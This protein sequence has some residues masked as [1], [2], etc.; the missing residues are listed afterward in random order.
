MCPCASDWSE[1]GASERSTQDPPRLLRRRRGRRHRP[2]ADAARAVADSSRSGS[3]PSP[4]DCSPGRRRLRHRDRDAGPRAHPAPR[5]RGRRADLLR[6]AGRR[7][8][9][10][11][12]AS[13]PSS[14]TQTRRP[15]HVG[16]QRRFDR[17]YRRAQQAV[18]RRARLRAQHPGADPRPVAA[19]R[20]LHPDERRPLPRLL[21]PRL[22]HHPLRHRPRG[23]HGLRDRRQQGRR[24]LH[25]GRRRRHRGGGADAR[26]RHPRLALGDALQRRAVTTCAWR[27]WAAR[28]RS[29]SATTTRSPS[30]SAEPGATYPSGPRHWSFMERF[31]PAYRAELTAFAAVAR[32]RSPSPCTVDDA[33][34]GLPRRRGLRAVPPRGPAGRP[35]RDPEPVRGVA[36]WAPRPRH[37]AHDGIRRRRH[38]PHRGR[39]LPAP[40][41][42]R[43]REGPHLREVPRRQRDQRRRRGG[44]PRPTAPRWSPAPG[45]DPVRALHP[46]GA[47]RLRRGRRVRHRRST[48]RHTR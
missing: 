43:P 3:P 9:R 35:R 42:R 30:P 36:R 18:R 25:R 29:A 40:A 41:R 46:R 48:A 2:D 15:V 21:H 33:L 8:A 47:A 26:R 38:R 4:A 14:S 23:G 44:A 16:F 20:G 10:R 17:G 7:D 31:L 28:A 22:R 19:P 13:S 1:S 39:H 5:G 6:E 37:P 27:S 24:L 45:A 32:G 11:D 12:D 34:A